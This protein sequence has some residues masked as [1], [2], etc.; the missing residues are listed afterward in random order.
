MSGAS[1]Y[2]QEWD[3]LGGYV[4]FA[5]KLT[6]PAP[7]VSGSGTVA[8]VTFKATAAS[9]W[10]DPNLE[11]TLD[12]INTKLKTDGGIEILHYEVDGSYSYTPLIG[13]LNSDGTVD[14]DDIY[15]ISL[16]YG[17][18]PGD[19]GWNRIADLN[20]DNTVDVL[21][22]QTAARHYGEDC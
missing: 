19:P 6:S 14:L 16:A 5:A 11:C 7:P 13:D 1:I 4:H 10:P 8:I 17:S 21:D 18:E 3:D 9:I 15:I 22:L 12:L 20:R 2:I